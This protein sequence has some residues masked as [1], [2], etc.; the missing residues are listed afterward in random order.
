MAELNH[1]D[2]VTVES[3]WIG[4]ELRIGED[5]ILQITDYC[6]RCVMTTLPQGDSSKDSGIL[7]T[8]ARH[9]EIHVGVYAEV[10]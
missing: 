6:P 7:H 8:A 10:C 9:N 4:Q 2:M 1:Q 5:V 3:K